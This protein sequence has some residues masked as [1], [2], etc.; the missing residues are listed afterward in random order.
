MKRATSERS[1]TAPFVETD[2]VVSPVIVCA[3]TVGRNVPPLKFTMAVQLA[4]VPPLAM[5]PQWSVPPFR[6]RIPVAPLLL[7][8]RAKVEFAEPLAGSITP[9]P[10]RLQMPIVF[11]PY[12]SVMPSLLFVHR[13]TPPLTSSVA[14]GIPLASQTR[15]HSACSDPFV[16][17]IHGRVVTF[18]DET[19]LP[20]S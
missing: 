7:R 13:T 20:L 9:S 11:A 6:F 1:K 12:P 17:M 14:R 2:A 5:L 15:M 19:L 16:T 3:S 10:E 4:P 8:V 18:A